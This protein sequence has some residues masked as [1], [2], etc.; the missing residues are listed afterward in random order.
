MLRGTPANQIAGHG[1]SFTVLADRIVKQGGRIA[2]VLPV[3]ALAGEA[4]SEVRGMLSSRYQVEFVVSSHDPEMR[5]MSYDTDIAEILL[6][7]RRLQE[8]ESPP[9]RSIFVNL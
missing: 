2:L 1:T 7:A 8:G 3:T 5:G 9:K 4:W 6:I